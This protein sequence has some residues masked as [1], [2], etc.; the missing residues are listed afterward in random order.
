MPRPALISVI[1]PAFNAQETLSR[2]V[3]S[4][5]SQGASNV[6]I[7][8]VN[9]ASTDKTVDVLTELA[10]KHPEIR[11]F[12]HRS[13]QGGGA[14]KNTGIA[15]ASG[16][17]LLFLDADDTL[18][19]GALAPLC[20]FLDATLPD[21][22]LMGCEETRR[23]TVRPLTEGPQLR[24]AEG[25]AFSAHEHPDCLFWPPSPWSKLYRREF[26]TREGL[27]F[28]EGVFEDIVWSARTTI[29]AS[30]IRVY[31]A[32]VYRYLT[33]DAETSI[34]TRKTEKNMA[35][36]KQVRRLR[37]DIAVESLPQRLQTSLSALATVHLVW[38]TRGAYKTL[39]DELQESFFHQSAEE[40]SWWHEHYPVPA[41]LDT[42]P[43]MS[44]VDRHSFSRAML[45]DN[46]VQW[47]K[48]L[49]AA[50]AKKKFRRVFR[51]GRFF[52]RPG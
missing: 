19:P 25:P 16:D 22:V 44:A 10:A 33:A 23:H 8:V 46:W 43:L 15:S 21:L 32:V 36:V 51:P 39:P 31:P 48:T 27:Q 30:S 9:D 20:D 17:Y 35:R 47:L 6:E 49:E 13:N 14:A 50:K 41:G 5:T 2:A 42:R 18:V 7:V 40:L 11:P 24:L 1:I 4:V 29:E 26:V 12:H 37:E 28:P 3:S 34:T 45:A 52:G 38:G